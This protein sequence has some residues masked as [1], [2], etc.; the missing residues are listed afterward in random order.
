MCP[1]GINFRLLWI[2]LKV[3]QNPW[4]AN[5]LNISGGLM[6]PE[7]SQDGCRWY[8]IHCGVRITWCPSDLPLFWQRNEINLLLYVVC[9]LDVTSLTP[10]GFHFKVQEG[11][12]LCFIM[13][14]FTTVEW[15][16]VFLLTV[17][18]PWP[19]QISEVLQLLQ[20]P[21]CMGRMASSPSCLSGWRATSF[22]FL[23][24]VLADSLSAS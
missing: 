10:Q 21:V 13:P 6:L 12:W 11:A 23:L 5:K 9:I 22:A 17:D 24:K 16:I 1:L 14:I 7:G 3:Y 4:E 15:S 18:A 8:F 20:C 19:A 2:S